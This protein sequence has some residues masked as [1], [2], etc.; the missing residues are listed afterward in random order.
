M[1][2]G[3]SCKCGEHKKPVVNRNW[4]VLQRNCNFSAFNG[5]H[6]TRSDYSFVQCHSCG[7]GWR[8][9]ADYTAIL[10]DGPNKYAQSTAAHE[11]PTTA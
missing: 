2:Q 6:Y 10:K 8:T 7:M 5:Y 3:I 11:P 4:F 1:S 9:R